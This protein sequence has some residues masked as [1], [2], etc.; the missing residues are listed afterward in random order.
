[1]TYA[2]YN[3]AGVSFSGNVNKFKPI[4]E[5]HLNTESKTA[6]KNTFFFSFCKSNFIS[7]L[8]SGRI[9]IYL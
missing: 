5:E 6:N 3:F 1:M 7:I 2:A 9:C 8:K 4:Q